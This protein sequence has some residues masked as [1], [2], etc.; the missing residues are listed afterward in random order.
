MFLDRTLV[1][2]WSFFRDTHLFFTFTVFIY[3]AMSIGETSVSTSTTDFDALFFI[4]ALEVFA[5]LTFAIRAT[6]IIS[7]ARLF[8]TLIAFTFRVRICAVFITGT[9]IFSRSVNNHAT[10]GLAF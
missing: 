8:F 1:F 2:S 9:F 5:F 10:L 4:I 3:L 6:L 7:R